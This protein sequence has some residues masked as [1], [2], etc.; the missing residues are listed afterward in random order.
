MVKIDYCS[1][2]NIHNYVLG[3]GESSYQSENSV[4]LSVVLSEVL[5]VVLMKIP[6]IWSFR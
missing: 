5:S 3:Y 1:D 6:E 2:E 4:V